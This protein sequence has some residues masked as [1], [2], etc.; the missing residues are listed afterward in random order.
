MSKLIKE[1]VAFAKV[2]S[3]MNEMPYYDGAN[4]REAIKTDLYN[5]FQDNT[6]KI[7]QLEKDEEEK[8]TVGLTAKE[9]SVGL[10]HGKIECVKEYKNRT[11]KSLMDSKNDVE[12]HF[13]INYLIFGPYKPRF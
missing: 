12:K 4:I 11:G 6:D 8:N 5:W 3:T 10:N 7:I 9:V 13:D 1:L 2:H